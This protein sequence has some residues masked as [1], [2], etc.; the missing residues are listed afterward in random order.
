MAFSQDAPDKKE[1]IL[2]IEIRERHLTLDIGTLIKDELNKMTIEIPTTK[3]YYDSVSIGKKLDNSFR[4]GSFIITG[5]LSD[6]QIKIK[7]KK[8]ISN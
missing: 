5:S 8:I 1:Y 3:K 6:Y 7:D 4:T 2:V